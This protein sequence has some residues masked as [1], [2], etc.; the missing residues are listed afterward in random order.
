MN[1]PVAIHRLGRLELNE[2]FDA[3][4]TDIA[5]ARVDEHGAVIDVNPDAP[6]FEAESD[7]EWRE[8]EK[9]LEQ[10]A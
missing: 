8:L 10:A 6:S 3:L 2:S 4:I 5:R 7:D 1:S 9:Y